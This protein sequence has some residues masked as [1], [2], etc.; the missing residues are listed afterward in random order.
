MEGRTAT[1]V[2][3]VLLVLVLVLVLLLLV[4]SVGFTVVN[5]VAHCFRTNGNHN[6]VKATNPISHCGTRW[7]PEWNG[8]KRV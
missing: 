7:W 3:V 5:V 2:W 6:R 1:F 4:T 8:M